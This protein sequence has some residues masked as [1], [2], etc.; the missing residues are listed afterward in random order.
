M[1]KAQKAA[2][3]RGENPDRINVYTGK[4]VKIEQGLFI[5]LHAEAQEFSGLRVMV[6]YAEGGSLIKTFPKSK[7]GK[8]LADVSSWRIT[9][10]E[11][12][13]LAMRFPHP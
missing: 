7:A 13:T 2:R 11:F 12:E 3:R 9:L 6:P 1:T 8:T 10:D 4:T 5:P